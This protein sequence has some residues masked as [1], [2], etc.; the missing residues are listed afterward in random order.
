MQVMKSWTIKLVILRCFHLVSQLYM[1]ICSIITRQKYLK[2]TAFYMSINF[3]TYF[4][5]DRL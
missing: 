5:F 2:K 1:P 3:L 4:S